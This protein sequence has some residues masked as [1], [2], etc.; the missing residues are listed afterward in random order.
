M[1]LRAEMTTMVHMRSMVWMSLRAETMTMVSMSSMAAMSLM[2]EMSSRAETTMK[3]Q[4]SLTAEMK[5]TDLERAKSWECHLA[6]A[7]R[8]LHEQVGESMMGGLKVARQ[9]DG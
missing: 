5:W 2:V 3:A 6:G 8:E 7:L 9:K 4:M 1:S